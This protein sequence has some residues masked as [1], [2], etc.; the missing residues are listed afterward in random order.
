MAD[1]KVS[2]LPSLNG[3]DVDAADLLYIIDSSAG[4]AGSKKINVGQYQ[5][6][7]YSAGTAN[8]VM[9]LNGS[10]VVT[11]GSGLTFD[12]TGVQRITA[13]AGAFQLY[14]DATPTRAARFAINTVATD[15]AE[16]SVYNGTAW[17]DSF[18]LSPSSFAAWQLGGS[19]RMRLDTSGNLGI[20][21]TSPGEKLAINQGNIYAIRTGGAKVRLADQNN[22]VSVE[23]L[24]TGGASNMVF[25]TSTATQMTLDASGNLGLG[26]TPS[27]YN[28]GRAVEVGAVGNAFWTTTNDVYLTA[29][30]FYQ[31]GYKYAASTFA[32]MYEQ[33]S[34]IHKWFTA[35]SGTAGNAITFTQAMTLDANGTLTVKGI[36][37][38]NGNLIFDDPGTAI[39][40]AQGTAG[41]TLALN[42]RSV[43]T[44]TTGGTPTGT[45]RARI[46]S[47]GDL[48]V[49]TTG[50]NGA[51]INAETASPT[52]NYAS[53]N[54]SGAATRYHFVVYESG[55]ERGSITSNGTNTSYNTSSDARLKDNIQPAAAADALIDA[56]QIRSFD[57]KSNGSH[58]RYGV[59]AQELEMVYPEAVTRPEDEN[60]MMAV[61]YS[62][63]VPMLI[64][65]I[66]TLRA[67]VAALEAQ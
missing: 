52:G 29:N 12:G 20:G 17:N 61:D 2:D 40:S 3:A 30:T 35:P 24:P 64:K 1:Q 45:E 27:T 63:L 18:Y 28:I 36:G 25:K 57:W 62:K 54:T 37:A 32:S 34:G 4:T 7:P 58:Q 48:L 50:G 21:T 9:Y 19:E 42:G 43:I 46:T 66:Q 16:M 51:K 49:G 8:G 22:E 33:T 44:F 60:R 65:E 59:V 56:I 14:K 10:N 67:R 13:T 41:S 11:T 39:V 15:A 53:N 55:T 5:L 6:A 23:S 47:G 26:V 31:S 38:G